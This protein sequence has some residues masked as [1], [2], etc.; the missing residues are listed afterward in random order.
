MREELVDDKK[1]E[2]PFSSI[3]NAGASYVKIAG[4][5]NDSFHTFIKSWNHPINVRRRWHKA[6]GRF[7]EAAGEVLHI[8]PAATHVRA[9]S[10]LPW[11]SE[12]GAP[13]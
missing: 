6:V 11:V 5:G 13:G 1:K 2:G 9:P 12:V 10:R 4:H 3:A 7:S 8:P